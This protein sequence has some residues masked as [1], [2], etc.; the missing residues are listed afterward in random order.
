MTRA[1]YL[2]KGALSVMG[3]LDSSFHP[4][5]VSRMEISVQLGATDD[6]SGILF[7]HRYTG[8]VI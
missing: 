4:V 5:P 7:P 6:S 3:P 8:A 2:P 1:H